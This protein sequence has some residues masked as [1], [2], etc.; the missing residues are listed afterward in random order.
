MAQ[1]KMF[2]SH[3]AADKAFCDAPVHAPRA[4]NADAHESKV[5]AP[6]LDRIGRIMA[7]GPFAGTPCEGVAA[8]AKWQRT[9]QANQRRPGEAPH[10]R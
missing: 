3:S 2:V 9:E 6:S 7:S 5:P 10:R 1:L 4:A 8:A